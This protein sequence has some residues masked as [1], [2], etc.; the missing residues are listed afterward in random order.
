MS[1]EFERIKHSKRISRTRDAE[2][3]QARIA[4]AHGITVR[5]LHRYSKHHF[6]DCGISNCPLCGNPRRNKTIKDHLTTQEK[7]MFQDIDTPND[8]HSNGLPPNDQ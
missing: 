2:L 5:E 1:D 7:R 8:R 6:M 4:R 3:R